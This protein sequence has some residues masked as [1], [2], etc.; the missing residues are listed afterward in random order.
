MNARAL[1]LLGENDVP[2]I[3][4]LTD[5]VARA[6]GQPWR[7]ALDA[8]E[9]GTWMPEGRGVPARRLAAAVIAL[10]RLVGGRPEHA[11]LARR[12][13]ALVLGAPAFTEAERV[14]RLAAAAVALDRSSREIEQL[15]WA[16]LPRERPV[17]LSTGRPPDRHVAA[18]ANVHILQHALR[19]AHAIQLA[20][21]GDA[22]PLLRGAAARGLL[23]T[24][25]RQH[26]ETVLEIVG[27]L[28]LCHG[29]TVYGRALGM[30]VPLLGSCDGWQLAIHAEAR[31]QRYEL[32]VGSPVLLPEAPP[33]RPWRVIGELAR[34]LERR[35]FTVE[36]APAPSTDGRTLVCPDLRIHHGGRWFA[37]E[38]IGFWTPAFLARKLARYAEVGLPDVILCVDATRACDDDDPPPGACIVR[39][40]N[41]IDADALGQLFA[42]NAV[43]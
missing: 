6:V 10:R 14:K 5:V 28:A 2:W 40:D 17:E 11:S 31:G 34:D 42:A 22:G 19:R 7:L 26:D 15:L 37:L 35:G 30:L 18:L 20:I 8:I 32:A 24:P 1:T 33:P 16:D 36:R 39:F 4:A 43:G 12:A 29:T 27:P 9:A 3:G 25:S 13:R 21:R 38:A 41:R 23:V